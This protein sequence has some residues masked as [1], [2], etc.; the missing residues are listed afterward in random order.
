[1]D[2]SSLYSEVKQLLSITDEKFDLEHNINH[3]YNSEPDENKLEIIGDILSFI[4]K[5]SM[6]NDIEPFKKSLYNCINKTLEIK[7]DS[8]FDF[9]DLL[10]KNSIMHFIQEYINYSKL[11][12]KDQVLEFLVDSLEKLKVQPLITN[13]GLLI[14]PMYQDQSY[15]NNLQQLKEVEVA[16]NMANGTDIQIKN[17][18]DAWLRSQEIS[19][20]NQDDLYEIYKQEFKN[21]ITKHNLSPDSDKSKKLQVEGMEMLTMK[22]TMLSLMEHI[23]DDSFEPIPIK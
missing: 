18:I 5:F 10:V 21:I 13:L 6:F 23:P 4:N 11:N 12:Q 7:P 3:Y 8:I 15:L 16:Y 14:K 1:M 20:D 22:L 2:L 9:E 17:E 19:L